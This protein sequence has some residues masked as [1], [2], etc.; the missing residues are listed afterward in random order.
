MAIAKKHFKESSQ[1]EAGDGIRLEPRFHRVI[2]ISAKLGAPPS[3][4]SRDGVMSQ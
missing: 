2:F 4:N 3:M 1:Q